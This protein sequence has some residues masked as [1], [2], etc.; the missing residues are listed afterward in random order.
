MSSSFRVPSA[1]PNKRSL[2]IASKY[3]DGGGIHL[4]MFIEAMKMLLMEGMS[5]FEAGMRESST[6][7]R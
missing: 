4:K 2:N 5:H 3:R 1:K 6:K 7:G